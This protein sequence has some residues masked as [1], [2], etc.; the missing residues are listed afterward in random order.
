VAKELGF[1]GRASVTV[2]YAFSS[3]VGG[4]LATANM[5]RREIEE[6]SAKASARAS[7]QLSR[8][9]KGVDLGEL[10]CPSRVEDGR[11]VAM[12]SKAAKDG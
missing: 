10:P 3:M 11:P 7:R 6:V 8:F 1:L 2:L 4:M 12:I 5:S 9:L